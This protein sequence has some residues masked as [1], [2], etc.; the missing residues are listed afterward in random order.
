MTSN[1]KLL[2]LLANTQN[3]NLLTDWLAEDYQLLTPTSQQTMDVSFDLCIVDGPMLRQFKSWLNQQ[4]K[5]VQPIFLPILL[6]ISQTELSLELTAQADELI[7]VPLK[8]IEL[9]IR[10]QGLL[11]RRHYSKRLYYQKQDIDHVTSQ[12]QQT[13]AIL[14]NREQTIQQQNDF[15]NNIIESLANPFYVINL[16]TQTVEIAN[17]AARQLNS[18]YHS[19]RPTQP[20]GIAESL[21]E[22]RFLTDKLQEKTPGIVEQIF[23]TEEGYLDRAQEIHTYPLFNETNNLVRLIKYVV[24][25]TDRKR[26]EHTLAQR[27][28]Y[29]VALVQ[30][31]K[32]LLAADT[33]HTLYD[34]I[35]AILGEA[36]QVSRVRL[37]LNQ[38][39]HQ[40]D[41]VGHQ[42]A[43]WC[44]D[45]IAPISNDPRLQNFRYADFDPYWLNALSKNGPLIVPVAGL[46][47]KERLL[48]SSFDIISF[49]MLPIIVNRE[50]FGFISFDSCTKLRHWDVEEVDFL[51]A[52]ANSMGMYHERYQAEQA[53]RE[54]E[55]RL[56]TVTNF[57]Y[58]WEYWV[59]PDGKYRYISPS[60]ERITGYSAQEFLENPNL[61]EE[62]THPDDQEMLRNHQ[63]EEMRKQDVSSISFRIITRQGHEE[64][65]GHVCQPIYDEQGQWLGRR[66]SS[67]LI[68]K[69]K[70]AEETLKEAN[71]ILQQLATLDGLTQVANRRRFDIYLDNEWRRS[72]QEKEPITLLLSDIDYFKRFND[73]YGHQAGD[74]CLYK[75]AQT[76]NRTIRQPTDLVARYGGEEFAIVLPNTDL[77]EAQQIAIL[78]QQAIA[79]LKIE[80]RQSE[81]SEYV[82]LSIGLSTVVPKARMA[83]ET[84]IHLAD[85]ALYGAKNRGRNCLNILLPGI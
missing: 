16:E 74:D 18:F 65:I 55:A 62:I 42:K 83:P 54:S 22:E 6:M 7:L 14:Q 71:L 68:T 49:L 80:H 11:E 25:I 52:V 46:P 48:F 9:E 20:L 39:H 69:F 79:L 51:W 33:T 82:T 10:L 21:Q 15:L 53:L 27:E 67:R 40:G 23:W 60:C 47:D 81:V 24:D 12:R 32:R 2:F 73:T 85:Q 19:N 37:L 28:R 26:A 70:L 34:D 43:E 50:F 29:L 30:V 41:L 58:N 59:G 17:S 4:K 36:T 5:I 44:A 35:I 1:K 63:A 77:A 64:W 56:R 75:V 61:L 57:A 78:I 66:V 38:R 76:I 31:K 45:D 8:K 84:L 3:Q 13:L 72:I